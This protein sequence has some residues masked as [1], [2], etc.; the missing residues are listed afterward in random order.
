[1]EKVHFRSGRMVFSY[2]LISE[3]EDE[4]IMIPCSKV[5]KFKKKNTTLRKTKKEARY[6]LFVEECSSGKHYSNYKRSKYY[7]YYINRALE[8]NPEV[9]I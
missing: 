3:T 9:L 7:E 4:Y 6:D 2:Y 5:T 8:E 1:M